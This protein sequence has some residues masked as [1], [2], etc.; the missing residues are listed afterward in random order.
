MGVPAQ[1]Y[2]RNDPAHCLDVLF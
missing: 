2:L 1:V